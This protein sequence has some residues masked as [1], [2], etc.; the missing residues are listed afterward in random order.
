MNAGMIAPQGTYTYLNGD[1]FEGAYSGD[2]RT[3]IGQMTYA[4][5][6]YSFVPIMPFL[7]LW[8]R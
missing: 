1:V 4:D 6:K 8:S 5:G 3:G 2:K 7:M